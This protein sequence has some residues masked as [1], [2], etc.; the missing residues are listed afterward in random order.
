MPAQTC[1]CSPHHWELA[2]DAQPSRRQTSKSNKC[3]KYFLMTISSAQAMVALCSSNL[4][5]HNAHLLTQPLS[6][7]LTKGYQIQLAQ[8][9]KSVG[10]SQLVKKMPQEAQENAKNQHPSKE[11]AEGYKYP[12]PKNQLSLCQQRPVRLVDSNKLAVSP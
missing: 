1:R 10:E 12:T 4:S 8:L 3:H 5:S 7:N 6:L 2:S 9:T 11:R